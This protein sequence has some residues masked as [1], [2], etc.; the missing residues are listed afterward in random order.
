[1]KQPK[2]VSGIYVRN[3]F[4]DYAGLKQNGQAD[5]DAYLHVLET[6]GRKACPKQSA[7]PLTSKPR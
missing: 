4:V 7:Q 6:G 3:G 1:M 2:A 5:L